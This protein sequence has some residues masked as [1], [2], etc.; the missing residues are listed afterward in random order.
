HVCRKILDD[1]LLRIVSESYVIKGN[2]SFQIGDIHRMLHSLVFLF[3]RQ[4]F[5]DTLRG[6]RRQLEHVAHLCDLLY[7]LGKVTDILEE[8]LDISDL[9][10]SADRHKS[11]E[12][13]H[14][15][16]AQVSDERHD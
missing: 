11:S 15:Y 5:K 13:C 12:D 9:D 8:G 6:C 10:R 16:I 1:R 3:L 7:R 4:E 2:V 14:Q